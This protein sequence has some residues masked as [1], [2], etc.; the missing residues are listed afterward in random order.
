[1]PGYGK[2]RVPVEP[3]RKRYEELGE[4]PSTIALRLGWLNSDMTP[5][6]SRVKRRLGIMPYNMG[7]GYGLTRNST[8]TYNVAVQLCEALNM[9]PWEVDI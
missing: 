7:R 5:D 1:M 6:T 2:G 3:F 8:V 9:D 4:R